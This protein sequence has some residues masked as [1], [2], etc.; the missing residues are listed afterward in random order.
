MRRTHEL[1]VYMYVRVQRNVD[2]FFHIHQLTACLTFLLTFRRCILPQ[3]LYRTHWAVE[4]NVSS[5]LVCKTCTW[6]AQYVAPISK[7]IARNSMAYFRMGKVGIKRIPGTSSPRQP[8][9]SVRCLR[10]LPNQLEG[11][12]LTCKLKPTLKAGKQSC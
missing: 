2:L 11:L 7:S 6:S 5:F 9:A 3:T 12:F 1:H 10:A 4:C 8:F